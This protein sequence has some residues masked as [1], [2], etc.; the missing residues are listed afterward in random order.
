MRQQRNR[1]F[2]SLRIVSSG[3]EAL[4]GR[5]MLSGGGGGGGEGRSADFVTQTNLVSDGAVPAAL[6]DPKLV[7]PWGISNLPGGP[8][9][10]SDNGAGLA[11]L[12]DGQGAKQALEVT[13]PGA[14]GGEAAPTGQVSNPGAA[15][16]VSVVTPQGIKSG[17]AKFIFAGEDGGISGWNPNVDPT[18]AILKVDHTRDG[19]IF[20]GLAKGDLGGKTYLF[21]TDFHNARVDVFD[22]TFT[23][24]HWAG[25]FGDP[26][27][28]KGF[29][30]FGV[31]NLNGTIYVTYAKQDADAEDDVAGRGNGFVDAFDTGG[32]LLGRLEHGRYFDSPWGLAQAPADWGQF[33]GD[34]LV[35]Q[36]GSGQ[37]AAFNSRGKFDGLLRNQDGSA[38]KIEGLWSLTFGNGAKN[39]DP[40][41]LYFTAGPNDEAD[42]LFG[43]L[44]L[45]QRP[46]HGN[47]NG[48]GRHQDDD[49]HG[50]DK[51]RGDD[52]WD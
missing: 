5:R 25:A 32:H 52:V 30:P 39:A 38:V 43:S 34:V 13:I 20:K 46:G 24:Q 12:Y 17:P 36:F 3:V 23:E 37:I 11:T 35:G 21:A 40:E 44:S 47:G 9:W 28:P 22:D 33:A 10:V 15:F 50:D 18:H 16:L 45:T 7:N 1:G 31:Q 48:H 49:D 42:G 4:E 27:V 41:K 51:D 8:F 2:A 19:A 29:A 14:G 26:R 6:V